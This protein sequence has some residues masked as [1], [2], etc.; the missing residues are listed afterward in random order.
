MNIAASALKL[1][2]WISQQA[3]KIQE[4]LGNPARMTTYRY[5]GKSILLPMVSLSIFCLIL[6]VLFTVKLL[7][8]PFIHKGEKENG[9]D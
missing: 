6:L 9:I 7:L 2:D 5:Y 3:D 1:S 4:R 8:M